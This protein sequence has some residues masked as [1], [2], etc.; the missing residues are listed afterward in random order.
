MIKGFKFWLESSSILWEH[1]IFHH[2]TVKILTAVPHWSKQKINPYLFILLICWEW[3]T[4]VWREAEDVTVPVMYIASDVMRQSTQ[5]TLDP[6]HSIWLSRTL[7][8]PDDLLDLQELDRLDG[9]G[10][11]RCNT[12]VQ[13]C[14]GVRCS[15][16]VGPKPRK[17]MRVECKANH[18]ALKTV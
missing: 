17:T 8:M 11:A 14:L 3:E 1:Q 4:Y 18:L 15:S 10:L 2:K 5:T 7:L 6:S 16:L 12:A 13:R 9:W